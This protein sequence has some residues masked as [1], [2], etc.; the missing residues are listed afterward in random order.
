MARSTT[1]VSGGEP[2]L[3]GPGSKHPVSR[4]RAQDTAG[5]YMISADSGFL[6]WPLHGLRAAKP[7]LQLHLL[8]R[9]GAGPIAGWGLL[10]GLAGPDMA[11]TLLSEGPRQGAAHHRT[12]SVQAS[13]PDKPCSSSCPGLWPPRCPEQSSCS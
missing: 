4:D 1:E 6:L 7:Y 9:C 3:A 8:T 13:G 12:L 2:P 10:R 11:Q 5:D